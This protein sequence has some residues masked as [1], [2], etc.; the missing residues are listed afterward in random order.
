M[1]N[2][3]QNKKENVMI[4]DEDIEVKE[5]EQKSFTSSLKEVFGKIAGGVNKTL[6]KAG[7][8]FEANRVRAEIK[9]L[10]LKI[11]DA[12][13]QIGESVY[14][15]AEASISRDSF[16]KEISLIEQYYSQQKEL[17]LKEMILMG[18]DAKAPSGEPK[19]PE[20]PDEPEEEKN[21]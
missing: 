3:D 5:A 14:R 4:G 19:T 13:R 8:T 17:L 11:S 18:K 16:E 15:S 7:D 20:L 1:E 12:Y 6:Q 2:N 9:E 21:E 10:D